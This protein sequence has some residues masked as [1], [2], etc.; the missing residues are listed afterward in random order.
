MLIVCMILAGEE[1][2]MSHRKMLSKLLLDTEKI[3]ELYSYQKI[4]L[5][6]ILKS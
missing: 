3:R 5:F 2:M 1:V 4:K 6:S